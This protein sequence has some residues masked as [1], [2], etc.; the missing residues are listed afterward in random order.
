LANHCKAD[1]NSCFLLAK[2]GLKRGKAKN[3]KKRSFRPSGDDS[4]PSGEGSLPSGDDSLPSG[5][6][7]L[8]SGEGS[9]PSG[10]GSL[11][12]GDG[13]LPSKISFLSPHSMQAFFLNLHLM[14]DEYAEADS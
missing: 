9:L 6:D 5:D 10:N 13:P 1:V 12:T 2:N 8:P 3:N 11:L 7:S 4:R 14:P